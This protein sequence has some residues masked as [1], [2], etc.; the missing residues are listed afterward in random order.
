MSDTLVLKISDN[1]RVE[2]DGQKLA[3]TAEVAQALEKIV[4]DRPD[5]VVSIEAEKSAHYEAIGMA[6]YGSTRAGFNGERLR[7]TIDGKPLLV[8]DDDETR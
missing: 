3:S 7:V 6:I 8:R 5:V 4:R 2:L 1:S